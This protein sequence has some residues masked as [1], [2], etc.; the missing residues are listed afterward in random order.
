[1]HLKKLFQ[2][3][4]V[5]VFVESFLAGAT[6]SPATIFIIVKNALPR[7]C[8]QEIADIVVDSVDNEITLVGIDEDEDVLTYNIPEQSDCGGRLTQVFPGSAMIRYTPAVG[9]IGQDSFLFTVTD[10]CFLTS[11]PAKVTITVVNTNPIAES[12]NINT[13][14]GVPTNIHL[15]A[16]DLGNELLTFTLVTPPSCGTLSGFPVISA[17]GEIIVVY[18]SNKNYVGTDSFEFVATNSSLLTSQPATVSINI[19][20]LPISNSQNASL[21]HIVSKYAGM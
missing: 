15:C 8:L 21:I 19:G 16:Q 9:F 12:K 1:M 4:I 3:L 11:L 13:M 20:A 6:S 2:I 5:F 18:T 17:N 14:S 7:A 10:D